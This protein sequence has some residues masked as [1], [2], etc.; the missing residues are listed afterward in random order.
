MTIAFN[1]T[2]FVIYFLKKMQA[3]P[4]YAFFSLH[5]WMEIF[6]LLVMY[7][8]EFPNDKSGLQSPHTLL[9]C[10]KFMNISNAPQ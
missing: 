10:L 5:T 3:K 1:I 6:I 7:F 4:P 9:N 8:Q 2:E